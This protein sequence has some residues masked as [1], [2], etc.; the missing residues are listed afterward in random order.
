MYEFKFVDEV[1]RNGFYNVSLIKSEVEKYIIKSIES[2][3]TESLS[4][5]R[6]NYFLM[7]DEEIIKHFNMI[8]V[9]KI[10]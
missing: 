3:K 5:L 2:E 7:E 4:F 6:N 8:T 9:N 10:K 1:N